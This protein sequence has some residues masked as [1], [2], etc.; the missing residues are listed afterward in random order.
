MRKLSNVYRL[1]VKELWGLFR[2][3]M[4]LAFIVYAFSVSIYT[5]AT[6]A[7]QTL[8]RVPIAIVD[9]DGSPLS[10]RIV[11][12]F[13][14]PHFVEPVMI[15]LSEVD[16][17][18]D[19]GLYTLVLDIPPNF[20]RDVLAGRRPA[21]QLNVDA[22]RM[23]QAFIGAGVVQQ[24][25]SGE[26]NEFLQGHRDAT[27]PPV[28]LALRM[29][30]NPTLDETWFV[31]VMQIINTVTML[32]IIL[33]GA[34]LI[35][36]REHGTIEHLLVMP[37]TPTEI[38]LA[39]VWSMALVVLVATALS[40]LF[41][42]EGALRVPIEGSKL[43]FLG[44][45]LLHLFSTTSMGIF[46]A[47][48]ARTMPQFGLLLMLTLMPLQMLSGGS[49]PRESMPGILQNLMLAAPTTHFVSASQAILYRGAGFDVVWP[50]FAAIFVIGCVFFAIAQ[51]RFRRTIAQLA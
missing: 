36:E 50:Q 17:G 19:A 33:T 42:I 22:T 16:P 2:D 45:V 10:G 37:V 21:L 3:P 47:T 44:I 29:R 5:A 4:L 48:V 14:P 8:N 43:L 11:S 38:M 41:V 6:S 7:P 51:R 13:Y 15:S 18:M 35:R 20:Q 28:D 30:F 46:M 25:V 49:T 26:V 23:S 31:G 9:E 12:A 39:K 40:M 34:A 24:I 32:S 27:P 1:G